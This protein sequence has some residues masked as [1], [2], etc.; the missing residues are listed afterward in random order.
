MPVVSFLLLTVLFTA[1]FARYENPFRGAKVGDFVKFGRY[2]Q[3]SEGGVIDIEWRVLA[4]ENGRVLAISRYGLDV[5]PF[6]ASNAWAD[7]DIRGWLNG[8]FYG[9]AFTDAEKGIIASSDP[10]KVFLLSKDEAEGY[11]D[12]D[13]DRRCRPTAYA[14]K[15]GA[16]EYNCYCR[17]WLRSPNPDNDRNAYDVDGSGCVSDC[18]YVGNG[19]GC[20]RPALWINLESE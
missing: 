10:G 1:A 13:K 2:S 17:W 12:S 9:V 20:A 4:V 3:T 8:E 7:S 5:R 11:F 14:E 6:G 19:D 18:S 16:S 15:N